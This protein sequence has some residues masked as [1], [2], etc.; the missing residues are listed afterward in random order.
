MQFVNKR[1]SNINQLSH[2]N[3][4]NIN[5][6]NSL[7]P[8]SS[9][10]R[11]IFKIRD[12]VPPG[13]ISERSGGGGGE[14]RSS[15]QP[16]NIINNVIKEDRP[17]TMKWG[18]PTWFFLHTIAEKVNENSFPNIRRELLDIILKICNNL[19][20]PDCATH[21]TRYMQ[22]VNFETIT[23]KQS[24]KDLLFRFHNSVNAKK[25]YA[26]FNYKDLDA[27][28]SSAITI[29]IIQNFMSHFEARVYSSRVSAHNFHR[30]L[31]ITQIKKW[32]FGNIQHFR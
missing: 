10:N 6:N 24:L 11:P 8:M 21:A 20:C 13:V 5:I 26:N 22:G 15:T 9:V 17:K 1:K 27:K 4:N 18:Q 16:N 28:Y 25:G 23:T 14:G 30:G 19:P 2:N 31:A 32:I 12:N 7:M 29:N 3:N